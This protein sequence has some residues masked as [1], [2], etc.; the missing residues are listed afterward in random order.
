MYHHLSFRSGISQLSSFI[1]IYH[2]EVGFH[3]YH[4]LS[5]FVIQ[6]WDSTIIIIYHHLSFR[7]GISQLSSFIIIYHHLSS[8][9]II[10]HLEVGFHNYHHLSSFVIQKWDSTSIIIYHRLS[11]GSGISQLSFGECLGLFVCGGQ[12]LFRLICSWVIHIVC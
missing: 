8:F 1:I 5:S 3:N 10:Y 12:K 11:F 2:L 6:K 9:I 4:H 7:S